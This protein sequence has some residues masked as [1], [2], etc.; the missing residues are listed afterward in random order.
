MDTWGE[1]RVGVPTRAGDGKRDLEELGM[2]GATILTLAAVLA[3]T[4]QA[5]A[6]PI[7]STFGPGNSYDPVFA[8]DIGSPGYNWDRGE[9][10]MY[11]CPQSR[12]CTLDSIEI[13]LRQVYIDC[14]PVGVN[15]I[16]VSLMTD[17]GGKPGTLIEGWSFVNQLDINAQ[18]LM[19][20]SVLHPVLNPDTP[21][22]LVASAPDSSTWAEW[23]KS[24]PVVLGTHGRKLG[25]DPW[26]IYNNI[27][28]GA[29]RINATCI[30]I[31]PRVPAP[32]ALILGGI[33]MLLVGY[34]RRRE[35][36]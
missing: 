18:I 25:S 27:T 32:G 24:S 23:L 35:M 19:G 4:G 11:S 7:Y 33:G 14:T 15:K 8:Y 2:K 22:W 21:Y 6:V 9:Q 31:P 26:E 5:T 1:T 30:E 28:Q 10:F 29:F 16:D 17:A 34:L 20:T 12:S 3:I 36:L 13:A